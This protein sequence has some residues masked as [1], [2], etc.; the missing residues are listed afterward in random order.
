MNN[1]VKCEA[2]SSI[3]K[4]EGQISTNGSQ[5]YISYTCP[6]GYTLAGDVTN[7][8]SIDGTWTSTVPSCGT[9]FIILQAFISEL[10][11]LDSS[12]F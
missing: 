10:I 9:T 12:K 7:F 2:L 5:T 3:A 8:C 11:Y 4:G 1:K 6:V